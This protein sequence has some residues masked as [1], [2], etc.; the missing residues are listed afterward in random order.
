MKRNVLLRAIRNY[1]MFFLVVAFIVSCCTMLFVTTMSRSM[2]LVLTSE[3]IQ[4][5]AKV[6]MLNALFLTLIL[7]VCDSIRRKLTVD[8][9]AR[10]IVEA[11]RKLT[12][13]DFSAR[14]PPIQSLDPEDRFA[15]IA[16]CFNKMAEE[17]SSIETLRSD[18]VSNVSHELKTPLAVMQSYGTLLAQPDLTE[19]K[20]M[21]Y[22]KG[23]TDASGRLATLISNILKLNKL[24][25][26]Q[27][28]P[29]FE[30]YD[31]TEQLCECLLAFED[32]W[33][34]KGIEIETDM[35]DSLLV[36]SDR[37]MM[38]LVWNNLF[39]NAIKFTSN[40][41]KVRLSARAEGDHVRVEVRDTGCG[42]SPDVGKHI[43]DKF[44]QG[45]TSHA[46]EGNGLGL[47]L[48][49]RVM[50]LVEG[51]ISV[52]SEVGKGTVFAVRLGRREG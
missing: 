3:N 46:T 1:V 10:Q 40:G 49:K 13:G 17:L 19:E 23:I 21:E 11:G 20:R 8:R 38:S 25:N 26:Q 15:E 35:E 29:V 30:T 31:L 44:Y 39:S 5:A 50:D 28:K 12:K 47:A 9:P 41:G 34:R 43:F 48:V 45:D 42:I 27:I 14:I 6:T 36:A 2:G 7:T 33:E 24:E 52:E 22:A 18:F 4:T 16:E 32:A 51:E 37:E